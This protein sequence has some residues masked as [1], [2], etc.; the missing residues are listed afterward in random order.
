MDGMN[1]GAHETSVQRYE[2]HEGYNQ[3]NSTIVHHQGTQE[4]YRPLH[5]AS[6]RYVP[7]DGQRDRRHTESHSATLFPPHPDPHHPR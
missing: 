5:R 7:G 2:Q 3:Y 6:I 4:G 1:S